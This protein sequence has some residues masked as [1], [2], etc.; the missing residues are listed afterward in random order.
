MPSAEP[1]DVRQ[2]PLDDERAVGGVPLDV[3]QVADL[4]RHVADAQDHA[5]GVGRRPLAEG[6]GFEAA[7][8][9]PEAWS[10]TAIGGSRA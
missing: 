2:V 7:S 4:G 6:L 3:E 1:V 8:R 5:S 10:T 9:R